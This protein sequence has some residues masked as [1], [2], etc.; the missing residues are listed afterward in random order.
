VQSVVCVQLGPPAAQTDASRP[1][2]APGRTAVPASPS[3]AESFAPPWTPI[4]A[5]PRA[6]DVA[7][8]SR[9]ERPP[10]PK[11]LSHFQTRSLER[12]RPR[13]PVPQRPTRRS[14]GWRRLAGDPPPRCGNAANSVGSL[15]PRRV[16]F[17]QPGKRRLGD[18]SAHA[19]YRTHDLSRLRRSQR[20]SG[21]VQRGF[22]SSL[23]VR[24][25]SPD[26]TDSSASTRRRIGISG[27]PRAHRPR[28]GNR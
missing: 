22:C 10:A 6:E 16:R 11:S 9:L 21:P 15:P 13:A 1:S 12:A 27:R 4:A 17:L 19:R 7:S 5:L 26:R 18:Q 8:L 28:A 23:S 2:R 24:G 25:C 3:R 14:S 20:G